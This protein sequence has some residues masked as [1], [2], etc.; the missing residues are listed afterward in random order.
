[1]RI[2]WLAQSRESVNT[3]R[4][5]LGSYLHVSTG[6]ANSAKLPY[7]EK[8][9]SMLVQIGE[10]VQAIRRLL[11]TADLPREMLPLTLAL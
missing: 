11:P 6:K 5:V 9:T 8:G 4:W 10:S 2:S 1:M 7:Q 3:L